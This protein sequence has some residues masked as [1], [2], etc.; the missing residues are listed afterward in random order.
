MK[1]D[2]NRGRYAY[3][4]FGDGLG[5]YRTGEENDDLEEDR[6][7][8]RREVPEAGLGEERE[9]EDFLSRGIEKDDLEGALEEG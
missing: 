8:G 6:E 4:P 1:G 7:K 9:K 2:V 5:E 3:E